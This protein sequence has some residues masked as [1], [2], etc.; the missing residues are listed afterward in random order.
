MIRTRGANSPAGPGSG[1]LKFVPIS[2]QN[3]LG[4]AAPR[5]LGYL[6]SRD[7]HWKQASAHTSPRNTL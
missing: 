5:R 3:R 2:I 7:R 4:L 1:K 6:D